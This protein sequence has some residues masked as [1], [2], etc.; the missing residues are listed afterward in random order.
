MASNHLQV[1]SASTEPWKK[2]SANSSLTTVKKIYKCLLNF[3]AEDQGT[4]HYGEAGI[5]KSAG[6]F[7]LDSIAEWADAGR[8]GRQ[9]QVMVHPLAKDGHQMGVDFILLHTLVVCVQDTIWDLPHLEMEKEVGSRAKRLTS[10][11]NHILKSTI[12]GSLWKTKDGW[13]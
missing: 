9:G 5:S 13:M 2:H 1:R 11:E 6:I 4:D 7:T 8:V 10:K 12:D 3:V